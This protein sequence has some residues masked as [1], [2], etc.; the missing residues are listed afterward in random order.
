MSGIPVV[1]E[2]R[3]QEVRRRPPVVHDRVARRDRASGGGPVPR[4]VR[5]LGYAAYVRVLAGGP[6]AVAGSGRIVAGW[7]SLADLKRYMAAIGAK[8]AGPCGEPWRDRPLGQSTL[9]TAA[10]CVK[11]F[12][13]HQAGLGINQQLGEQLNLTRSVMFGSFGVSWID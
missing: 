3:V 7:V 9:T 5:R 6:F 4:R 13:L 10:S 11:G 1:G 12:Y 8:F 2:L